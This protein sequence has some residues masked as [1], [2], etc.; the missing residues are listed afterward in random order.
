[1][2]DELKDPQAPGAVTGYRQHDQATI[3]FVNAIK[4]HEKVNGAL[5][6]AA[7]ARAGGPGRGEAQRQLALARSAFEVAYMHLV[8]SV[9]LPESPWE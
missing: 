1:V 9:F 7:L 5:Y 3:D 8:R 2:S 4:E 6:K